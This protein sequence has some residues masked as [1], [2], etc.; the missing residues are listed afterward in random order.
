[1]QQLV[2]V[3]LRLLDHEWV[4]S[5][6]AVHSVGGLQAICS[7]LMHHMQWTSILHTVAAYIQA[8]LQWQ[9]ALALQS[10]CLMYTALSLNHIDR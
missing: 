2:Y 1:M 9:V 7:D 3:S 4:I 5:Q 6:K 10:C 8:K